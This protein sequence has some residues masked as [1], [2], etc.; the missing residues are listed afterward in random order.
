MVMSLT[1]S[2][3]RNIS[4]ARSGSGTRKWRTLSPYHCL[5]ARGYRVAVL[6]MAFPVLQI[7][8]SKFGV[9][10]VHQNVFPV[11]FLGRLG[12]VKAALLHGVAIHDDD[13]VMGNGVLGIDANR[14]ARIG[15]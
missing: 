14:N 11:L 10:P 9:V 5:V 6:P 7:N 15:N 4:K 2:K 8:V 13:F 3:S 12:V 1:L